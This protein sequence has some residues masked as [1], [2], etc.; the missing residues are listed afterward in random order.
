M[1]ISETILPEIASL[2]P[3]GFD[4]TRAQMTEKIKPLSMEDIM[5]S[6]VTRFEN[7]AAGLWNG[8]NQ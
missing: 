4:N 2:S 7:S 6:R 5:P 1:T 8:R 3:H